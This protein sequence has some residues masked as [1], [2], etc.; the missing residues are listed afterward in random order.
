[1]RNYLSL[2]G[3]IFLSLIFIVH[4]TMKVMDFE[5]FWH[6]LELKGVPLAPMV[7]IIVVFIELGGGLA[8][9]IG[10]YTRFFTSIMAIYLLGV[11]L[12]YYPFWSDTTLFEDFMR[13]LAIVGGL[14]IE[15]YAGAGKNSVDDS[16][17]FDV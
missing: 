2:I 7:S 15:D 11:T 9:L 12:V 1:M 17:V 14:I 3:R 8:I 10:F 13:N 4:G 16:H 6:G 5:H